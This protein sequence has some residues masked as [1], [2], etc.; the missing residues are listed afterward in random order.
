LV[1]HNIF[2]RFAIICGSIVSIRDANKL[3][4][5]KAKQ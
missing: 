3:L 4:R 2:K 1:F 5:K